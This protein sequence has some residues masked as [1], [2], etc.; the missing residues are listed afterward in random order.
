M[1]KL[2]IAQERHDNALPDDDSLLQQALQEWTYTNAEYLVNGVDIIVGGVK[3]AS[4]EQYMNELQQH[5]ASR[6]DEDEENGLAVMVL[7]G[8]R[9]HGWVGSAARDFSGGPDVHLDI[10]SRMLEKH[11]EQGL[12]EIRKESL[13]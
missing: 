13:E 12:E 11:A 8:L 9:Q 5:L 10:A 2:S 7:R 6:L 1:N 3:V 4:F